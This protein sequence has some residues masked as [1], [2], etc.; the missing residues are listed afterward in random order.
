MEKKKNSLTTYVITIIIMEVI[1]IGLVYINTKEKNNTKTSETNQTNIANSNTLY[2]ETVKNETNTQTNNTNNNGIN[3]SKT[4]EGNFFWGLDELE[5]GD[6]PSYSFK[7]DGTV[8]Q[9]GNYSYIGTYKINGNKINITYNKCISP[10][11]DEKGDIIDPETFTIIDENNITDKKNNNYEKLVYNEITKE[12]NGIDRLYVTEVIDNKNDTYTLKGRICTQYTLNQ[13]QLDKIVKE[14]QIMIDYET[15][16]VKKATE[17]NHLYELYS[18]KAKNND[19]TYY[20][21]KKDSDTYYIENNTENPNVYK[22]TSQFGKITVDKSVMV[23]E[24]VSE[25]KI[26]I[27]KK[28]KDI[29]TNK[30]S[31]VPIIG[32]IVCGTIPDNS[33][34]FEFK[35]GKCTAIYEG[36]GY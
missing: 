35:N 16:N 36:Y 1:I 28:F 34:T 5:A 3:N 21:M 4:I 17:D 33:C 27:D 25:K 6:A 23:Q 10:D 24:N 11:E 31:E 14:K 18:Q 22:S 13:E 20:I 8:S 29:L 15:Y 19:Y 30:E 7:S 2:N 12:L 32:S 9:D 26:T